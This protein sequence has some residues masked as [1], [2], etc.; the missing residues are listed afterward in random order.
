MTVIF[1]GALARSGNRSVKSIFTNERKKSVLSTENVIS[2][3]KQ[4]AAFS[5]VILEIVSLFPPHND[6]SWIA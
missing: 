2:E 1:F 5:L 6:S 3:I 4:A